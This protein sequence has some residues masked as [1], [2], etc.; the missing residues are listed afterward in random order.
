M[1]GV[2]VRNEIM[3]FTVFGICVIGVVILVVSFFAISGA[4]FI[5][6][7][8]F[9]DVKDIVGGFSMIAFALVIACATGGLF[10]IREFCSDVGLLRGTGAYEV[11]LQ[12]DVDMA[13]FHTQYEI[14]DY[15]NGVYTV[16][17]K[18]V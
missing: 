6:H 4:K 16:K 2:F 11:V 9:H 3:D 12:N 8:V 17:V 10:N 15:T 14:I 5:A 18:G 1:D 13:E 7:G